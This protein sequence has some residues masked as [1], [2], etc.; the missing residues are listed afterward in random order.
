MPIDPSFPE[1]RQLH[2]LTH[3][4]C[5]VV[6]VED[7]HLNR[8]KS[9]SNSSSKLPKILILNAITA[10]I[11]EYVETGMKGMMILLSSMM[12]SLSSMMILLSR[13]I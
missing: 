10:E 2:I 12:I 5:Q 3:S 7:V 4:K 8:L 6:I 1:D 9:M 11:E 13:M